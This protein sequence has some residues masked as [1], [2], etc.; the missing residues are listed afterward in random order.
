MKATKLYML[1]GAMAAGILAGSA[2]EA[3]RA[4]YFLEGYNYRHEIG[5]AHV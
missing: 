5:R 4:A 2:Q 1:A 3:S